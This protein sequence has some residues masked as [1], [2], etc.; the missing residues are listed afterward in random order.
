MT[1]EVQPTY[2][3]FPVD[4]HRQVKAFA[5]ANDLTMAQVIRAA[6]RERVGWEVPGDDRQVAPGGAS[7]PPPETDAWDEMLEHTKDV[8]DTMCDHPS[9]RRNALSA[10]LSRCGACGMTKGADGIWR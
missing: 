8:P 1:D 4:L 10:G 2:V 7:S 9:K 3:R 5:A 6:V